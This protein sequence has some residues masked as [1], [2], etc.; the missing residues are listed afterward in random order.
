VVFSTPND[1]IFYACQAVMVKNR[2]TT[3]TGGSES[4]SDA[5]ILEG[6]QSVGVSQ[7]LTR[8][9]LP[10]IGRMQNQYGR[11]SK[12]IYTINISRVIAKQEDFFYNTSGLASYTDSHIL[13]TATNGTIGFTGFNNRLKNY[14][15][16][17]V[18]APDTFSYVGKGTT[19]SPVNK[20]CGTMTYRCCLLTSIG[21]SISINGAITEDL[22]FTTFA[23]TQ[24]DI[25]DVT[26]FTVLGTGDAFPH[27]NRSVLTREDISLSDCVIPFEADKA[28]NIGNSLGGIAILGLQQIDINIEIAYRDIPDIGQWRGSV[29]NQAEMNK[30][31][32]VEL[33]VGVTCTF[34]GVTRAQYFVN[35]AAQDETVTDTYHSKGTYGDE[36]KGID[37]YRTDRQI[38]IVANG[39]GGDFFQWNLGS[40]NYISSFDVTGGDA[41]GGGNVETSMS[42]QNDH[43][44]IFL[45]K[46][47]TIRDFTSTTTY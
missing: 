25:T 5:L 38:K 7:E 37:N 17:I 30:F 28:Y 26:D 33:P 39:T 22:T 43:S 8:T 41:G 42:F 23:Y 18:Y 2:V 14:D 6:V 35:S 21:Y 16:C 3:S 47:S 24:D 11:W 9:S 12:T 44:E 13:S 46:D 27:T 1:R 19:S 32:Q 29:T 45:L 40:K 20:E 34:S 36:A 10:D 31:R 15:L 4:P